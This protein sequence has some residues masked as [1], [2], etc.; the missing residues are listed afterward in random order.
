M[1]V[2]R[3]WNA[4]NCHHIRSSQLGEMPFVQPPHSFTFFF[5]FT[6][7]W[8]AGNKDHDDHLL[9]HYWRWGLMDTLVQYFLCHGKEWTGGQR[10][11]YQHQHGCILNCIAWTSWL[12]YCYFRWTMGMVVHGHETHELHMGW[13]SLN[14]SGRRLALEEWVDYQEWILPWG[15]GHNGFLQAKASLYHR[16]C[17]DDK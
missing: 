10:H 15:E 7:F 4:L 17:D 16:I 8:D 6:L 1:I 2:L 12:Y 11:G 14:I 5:S 9:S 3:R 13:L